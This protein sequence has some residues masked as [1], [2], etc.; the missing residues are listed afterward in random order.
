[1]ESYR[2]VFFYGLFM[3]VEMLKQKGIN[4]Q[5]PRVAMIMDYGLRIGERATLRTS[6]GE[7]S[8]GI[9]MQVSERDLKILYSEDSVSDY[10]PEEVRVKIDGGIEVIAHCYNLPGNLLSGSNP[11]YAKALYELAISLD[12]P[13]DYLQKIR[14]NFNS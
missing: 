14:K 8:Y 2:E 1:M 9:L 5:N 4:P 12:F 7:T 6:P 13:S 3:D 11:S 10:V